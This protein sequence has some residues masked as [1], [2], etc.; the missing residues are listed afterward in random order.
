VTDA[1]RRAADR[2]RAGRVK[3]PVPQDLPGRLLASRLGSLITRPWF[4]RVV[5]QVGLAAYIPLSRAWAAAAAAEGDLDRFVEEVPLRRVPPGMERGLVRTL[6]RIVELRAD[7]EAMNREWEHVFFGGPEVG[8]ERLVMVERAR[9]RAS[10]TFMKGRLAFLPLRFRG[11]LPAVKYA[12]PQ[13]AEVE[14]RHGA[15]LANIAGAY[16]PPD[17]LPTIHESRRIHGLQAIEYWLRY[18]SGD[19][20]VGETA[21]A[22]VFEPVGL[23]DPPSLVD[24]HGLAVEIESLDGVEDGVA[25]LVRL[26]VRVIRIEAP[27]HNRRRPEG[28][29]GGEPFLASPP[30]SALDLFS[31]EVRELAMLVAWCRGNSRGRVAVGGTSLGALASQLVASH[32]GN[33]PKLYRPD[34][35]FLGTTTEDVGGLSF[36][37]SIA[38]LVG[39]PGV[40]R[41]HGWSPEA[42]ARWRPLTDP[43]EVPPLDPRDVIM[44]L[45]TADDVTPFPRGAALAKRWRIPHESLFLRPMG[46]F[47]AALDL[48][49]D[50][51]P[52]RHLARR[53]KQK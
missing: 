6:H 29:Y 46:H 19:P 10:D 49:R 13:P 53:L 28:W 12:I 42:F 5:L 48:I 36:D 35:V 47:S 15:R 8:A 27:W 20:A 50:P 37:S 43:V 9:R 26:G 51:A 30:T 2:I 34:A 4:D 3:P 11:A 7:H 25:D 33:W 18:P 23:K 52:L 14:A 38:K 17:P 1:G 31:A 44:V 21:W 40:L 16:L 32:C 39:L 41:A 45:G 22:H 24:A